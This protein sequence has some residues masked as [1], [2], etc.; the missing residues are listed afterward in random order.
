MPNVIPQFP[1]I[2]YSNTNSS[3]ISS[4]NPTPL[5]NAKSV[6]SDQL[7]TDNVATTNATST[8][9]NPVSKSSSDN[10]TVLEGTIVDDTVTSTASYHVTNSTIS[11]SEEIAVTDITTTDHH[12]LNPVISLSENIAITDVVTTSYHTPN[13]TTLLSEGIVMVDAVSAAQR[14]IIPNA[15]QSWQFGSTN[16]TKSV[17]DTELV[18]EPN[19]TSLKLGGSGYL[20]QNVNATK[21]LSALTLSAW[22]KPDYSQGSPQFTVISKENTFLLAVNNIIPPTKQ[23]VFSVFDGIK[24]QTVE[25]NS[26][27]PEEW[28]HLVATFNGSSIAIYING[29]LEST[30][31]TSGIL[32]LS[33]DG[34]LTTKTVDSISSNADIV[35]GAYYNTIRNVPQNEFSGLNKDVNLYD[36]LLNPS[37]IQRIYEQN[38]IRLN[39]IV[40]N[41]TGIYNNSTIVDQVTV[42]DT[43]NLRLNT[44]TSNSGIYN[45]TFVDQVSLID[46]VNIRLNSTA[47][48]PTGIYNNSTIVDQVSSQDTVNLVLNYTS[49]GANSI[50]SIIPILKSEK[51]GFLITENPQ[52]Q[53]Q[54]LDNSTLLKQTQKE[55]IKDLAQLDSVEGNLNK[56]ESV[57]NATHS[58][59]IIT[60]EKINLAQE[61]IDDAQQQVQDA[62]QQ[63][64]LAL[65]QPQDQSVVDDA[66]K[67]THEALVQIQEAKQEIQQATNQ[68]PVTGNLTKTVDEIKQVTTQISTHNQTVQYGKWNGNNET[69]TISVI[70]P[71]GKPA[72]TQPQI[73]QIVEGK[74]NITLSSTRDARPGVYTVTTTLVKDGKTYTAEDQYAWGLV[75]L[76]TQKSIYKPGE[77]A[78][79]IIV[80]LDNGGHSV[81]NATIVMNVHDPSSNVTT[82]T[83][84]NGI[85][86]DPECGL[87]NAHYT[88]KSEGNYTIDMTAQNP[89]GTAAFSTSFSV[90]NSYSFD[91]VRTADSKIDPVDNPNLFNVTV[92]I[93]SYVN[94]TSVTIQESV[95][96]VF[97]VKTDANVKTVGD[98]KI[99][100]WNKDLIGNKTSIKYSYSVP[101]EFP[102]LYALGPMQ[103]AYE[104]NQTFTE[105]R[106]WFVANDPA[107]SQFVQGTGITVK[108]AATTIAKFTS[109]LKTTDDK[110]IIGILHWNIGTGGNNYI[111]ANNLRLK[112]NNKTISS[113]NFALDI[114]TP[115]QRNTQ[116]FVLI[117]N[118][119][120]QVAN[121][122]YNFSATTY[123]ATN[124][125]ATGQIVVISNSTRSFKTT[126]QTSTPTLTT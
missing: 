107:N 18:Q 68:V 119:T 43:I 82:L 91:I 89:S 9:T 106:P 3:T 13:P 74:F 56:T 52:L 92:D 120:T 114:G 61:K 19:G 2:N 5:T 24:W 110:L 7:G 41:S 78:N 121:P 81:C 87:Y 47:S 70:G 77:V 16:Q 59:P 22:V 51:E 113:N 112:I 31:P 73:E 102:R 75:S 40:S 53:F 44:T 101:L 1:V 79:F 34:K 4:L 111:P 23:A 97:N 17:G 58:V 126:N 72:S 29:K 123:Y 90:Q 63:I 108:T 20:T 99:L 38:N 30:L 65:V 122:V 86:P 125:V 32:T 6:S 37:Q 49:T 88:T 10:S 69:V 21:S 33:V 115:V 95:P 11:L 57:L 46:S 104:K 12:T 105:A 67:Q 100:T 42:L 27:I 118:D 15:T 83:S 98:T 76:N 85:T 103:I 71:D 117:G 8:P 124:S 36:S 62:Q 60:S 54:Y 55:I 50:M 45:S 64:Q 14:F 84:E 25:S 93:G 28:T 96:S 109:N 66:L 35:I 80:V 26:S 48:N 94:A 39:S 116:T